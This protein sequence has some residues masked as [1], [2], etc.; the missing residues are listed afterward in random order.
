MTLES[1]PDPPK[2]QALTRPCTGKRLRCQPAPLTST[3]VPAHLPA[4]QVGELCR[5]VEAAC[6]A[7]E[8]SQLAQLT[9]AL[10]AP[11]VF[12]TGLVGTTREALADGCRWAGVRA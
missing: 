12:Q 3:C 1:G 4:V 8:G 11:T 9:Q 5:A 6:R 7:P 10:L 2:C